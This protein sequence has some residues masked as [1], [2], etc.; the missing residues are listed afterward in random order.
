[1]AAARANPPPPW[2]DAP[3]DA[4]LERLEFWLDRAVPIPGLG[5]RIGLDGLIG[6]IP[7]VGDAAMA[8]VAATIVFAAWRRGADRALLARMAWN[9]A[10][11]GAVGAIPIAGDI[12]DIAHKANAK[13][14]RL[15]REALQR[16][17]PG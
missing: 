8:I 12:F 9:V 1:M 2:G 10:L 5:V 15:L 14:L 3:G 6:L 17:P 4:A 7:G 13:N 11:D 16:P